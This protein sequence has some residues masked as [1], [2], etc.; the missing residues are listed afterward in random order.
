[1]ETVG[2]L[3]TQGGKDLVT[4]EVGELAVRVGRVYPRDLGNLCGSAGKDGARISKD[5]SAHGFAGFVGGRRVE[6]AE[7]G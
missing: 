1:M 5:A 6:G 7:Q 2:G 3:G 4:Q